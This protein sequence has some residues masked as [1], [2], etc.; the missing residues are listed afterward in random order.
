MA[1]KLE[2]TVSNEFDFAQAF[3][4]RFNLPVDHD[5][6]QMPDALGAGSIKEVSLKNGVGLCFHQ[7]QLK[8]PFCA[9]TI[10]CC[11]RIRITHPA[12]QQRQNAGCI[13]G[14]VARAGTGSLIHNLAE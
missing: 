8:Q 12:L 11:R 10:G 4:D 1:I 5:R 9:Q 14:P 7:Y 6:V 2:F 3:A 13:A